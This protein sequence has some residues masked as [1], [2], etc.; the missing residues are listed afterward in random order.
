MLQTVES[1]IQNP[2]L[3]FLLDIFIFIF[4]LCFGS[5]LNVCIYRIPRG[6]SI[7]IKSSHCTLCGKK[8]RFY[9]NVPV[10]SWLFLRGKCS[11]CNG[12]ISIIYPIVEIITAVIILLLWIKAKNSSFPLSHFFLYVN[13]SLLFIPAFFI[14]IKH[15]I[16]PNKLTYS[17]ILISFA[18][19]FLF[20][21]LMYADRNW[22]A[23]LISVEGFLA[24]GVFLGVFAFIGKLLYKKT[25]IGWGDVKFIAALGAAFGFY[26]Y[27]WLGI[28]IIS[29]WIGA[30]WGIFLIIA[31][32]KKWSAT[33]PFGPFLVVGSY[34]WIFFGTYIERIY[35]NLV[36][37]LLL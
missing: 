8:I 20:P 33:L 25:V 4:G 9:E 12:K 5:F 32:G 14:D 24:A 28:L 15:F 26:S 7:T 37:K 29:A 27:A 13:L 30:L 31:K 11:N 34:L 21:E 23:L 17:V 6:E 10:L 16:I 22:Q 19:S 1:M 3:A 35:F 2:N 36:Q 18:L